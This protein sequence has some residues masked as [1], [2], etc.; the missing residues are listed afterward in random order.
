MLSSSFCLLT[1]FVCSLI[2]RLRYRIF[3]PSI[4][5]LWS[6]GLLGLAGSRDFK[7]LM[8]SRFCA[9]G[10][11]RSL[12]LPRLQRQLTRPDPPLQSSASLRRRPFLVSQSSPSLS[13]DAAS[14]LFVLLLGM[15]RPCAA[16]PTS[17]PARPLAD[18]SCRLCS[19]TNGL[20]NLIASPIVYGLAKINSPTVDTYQIVYLF[21]GL[22][23]F[24]VVRLSLL[25]TRKIRRAAQLSLSL[26]LQG[27]ASYWWLSDSPETASFLSDEDKVKAVERLKANNQGI[28]SHKVCTTC[29]KTA[30]GKPFLSASLTSDLACSLTG[31]KHCLLSP[32]SSCI[33]SWYVEVCE[34]ARALSLWIGPKA[35]CAQA[36]SVSFLSDYDLLLQLR[37]FRQQRVRSHHPSRLDRCKCSAVAPPS[38][39]YR[40][41]V[42]Q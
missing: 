18:F 39:S 2:V 11:E 6:A 12:F 24:V 41:L 7:S 14:S 9:S 8:A 17:T 33:F 4:I 10:F 26:S 5:V 13:G 23:S 31:S 21:F 27:V 25:R 28:V 16:L 1:C 35:L 3:V 32:T 20:A 29:C 19:G 30:E 36:D 15:V 34:R 40:G 38:L 22:W 37:C 42:V